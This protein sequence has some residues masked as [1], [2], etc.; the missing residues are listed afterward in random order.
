VYIPQRDQQDKAKLA[1]LGVELRGGLRSLEC[2][3][4]RV[5]DPAALFA[6]LNLAEPAEKLVRQ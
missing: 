6:H 5:V 3:I 4:D 2:P 1:A